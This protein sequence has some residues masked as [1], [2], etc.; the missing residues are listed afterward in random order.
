[1][2]FAVGDH[3]DQY[4][5]VRSLGEGAYA[6]TYEAIDTTSGVTVGLKCLNPNLFADPHHFQR[7]RREAAIVSRLDHPNA[8]RSHDDHANRTEPHL[9]LEFVGGANLRARVRDL[10]G[11][12]PI[13]IAVD[14]G[15]QLAAA[16]EY[17]HAHGI[18]H[19]DLKPDNVLVTT[20]GGLR[21]MD[22]GTALLD[23]AERRTWRHVGESLGTPD[24]MSPEQIKGDRGD[25]RGDLY[26]LG[27]LMYELL[28]GQVPF[29]GDNWMV[30]MALPLV[31]EPVPIRKH[32]PDV[33]PQLE[34]V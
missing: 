8:L 25:A 31:S 14:W 21:L 15:R 3:I 10:G 23:G 6:E 30:T 19:R 18:V 4:E 29:S 5:R 13:P 2:R 26:S 34:A 12:V 9:V 32:R 27:V 20:D 28:T 33:S 22:F 1:M 16:R 11:P 24:P 7:F 17:L